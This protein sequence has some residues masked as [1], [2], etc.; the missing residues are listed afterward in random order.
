MSPWYFSRRVSIGAQW[1]RGRRTLKAIVRRPSGNGVDAFRQPPIRIANNGG[2]S[3]AIPRRSNKARLQQ[4][5]TRHKN[6]EGSQARVLATNKM[7]RGACSLSKIH[8]MVMLGARKHDSLH[9]SH[10]LLSS[11]ISF[12]CGDVTTST[13]FHITT[14]MW[15]FTTQIW[16][17]F[18]IKVNGDSRHRS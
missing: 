1:H 6:H 9:L 8:V 11:C 12:S 5:S 16:S 4:L 17:H 10:P 3:C 13:A 2:H 18:R 14:C 7:W 15:S